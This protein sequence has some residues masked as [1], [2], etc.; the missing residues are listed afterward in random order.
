MCMQI[1]SDIV[2]IAIIAIIIIIITYINDFERV[3]EEEK[4]ERERNSHSHSTISP[5][6]NLK[7]LEKNLNERI[8]NYLFLTLF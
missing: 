5:K 6:V 7:K 8:K 1:K 2:I 3:C 4:G